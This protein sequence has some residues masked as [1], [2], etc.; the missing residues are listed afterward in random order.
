MQ[1]PL[2]ISGIEYNYVKDTIVVQEMTIKCLSIWLYKFS[3]KHKKTKSK[4]NRQWYIFSY[5]E[6][7]ITIA[8]KQCYKI[9]LGRKSYGNYLWVLGLWQFFLSIIYIY[10]FDYFVFHKFSVVDIFLMQQIFFSKV[11]YHNPN[12]CK[13]K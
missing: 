3:L 12:I 5:K 9:F 11:C 6:K 4:Y 2:G 1:F 7:F 13:M 10:L 8:L